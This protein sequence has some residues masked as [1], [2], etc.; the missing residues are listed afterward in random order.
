M[1]RY[2]DRAFYALTAVALHDWRTYRCTHAV[3]RPTQ[4]P[5]LPLC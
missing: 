4:H 5:A 1:T 3:P 2:L